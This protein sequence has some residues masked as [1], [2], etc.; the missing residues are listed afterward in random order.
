MEPRLETAFF[1]PTSSTTAGQPRHGFGALA[2][3]QL[4]FWPRRHSLTINALSRQFAA[5]HPAL[6]HTAY[7]ARATTPSNSQGT[8]GWARRRRRR[9]LA[10]RGGARDCGSPVHAVKAWIRHTWCEP[11]P[12]SGRCRRG[13]PKAARKCVCTLRL[14]PRQPT[15][16]TT[17]QASILHCPAPGL[18]VAEVFI[19]SSLIGRTLDLQD[20]HTLIGVSLPRRTRKVRMQDNIGW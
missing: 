6:P 1:Y 2:S 9:S 17:S 5:R 18:A 14:R 19:G 11:R 15:T 8:R 13:P 7:G 4:P 16:T 3:I 20:T 10:H 12:S